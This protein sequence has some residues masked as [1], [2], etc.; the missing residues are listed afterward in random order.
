MLLKFEAQETEIVFR[1]GPAGAC[2][3]N[4]P[5]PFL[6]LIIV[7]FPSARKGSPQNIKQAVFSQA[8]I[9][10]KSFRLIGL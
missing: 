5:E 2:V 7:Y 6:I 3:S 1:I 8:G 9:P 4:Y 10:Q